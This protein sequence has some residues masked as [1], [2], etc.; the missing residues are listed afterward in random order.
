M[1]K[2]REVTFWSS[3]FTS[4]LI[5]VFLPAIVS[6]RPSEQAPVHFVVIG[7]R[8]G[9]HVPGV[10]EQILEEIKRLRPDFTINV[11]DM[12][13]GYTDDTARLNSQWQQYKSL[14]AS[15]PFPA[16]FVPGNHDILTDATDSVYRRQM[17]QPYYSFDRGNLHFIVLQ[18][19]RW[20]K[21]EDLP[22]AQINWLIN[23][24]KKNSK[25]AYT[26][27]FMH[28]PFWY[29]T[30]ALGKPDTLHTLF[31]TYGVDAVFTGHFHDYFSGKYDGIIYTAIGSSG[32]ET[33]VGPSGLQYHYGWVTVDKGG[34]TISPIRMGSVLPWNEVTSD[35]NRLVFD[36]KNRGL[37]V[38]KIPVGLQMTVAHQLFRVTAANLSKEE[39]I[40]D[41]LKWETPSNW[42]I[43]PA[44]QTI[45]LSPGSVGEF[46]F[47]ASCEGILYPLPTVSLGFP[48][49][50]GTRTPI[51]TSL[52]VNRR[53][54][55]WPAA[56]PPS[57]DGQLSEN[58]WHDPTT[59]FFNS[60][61]SPMKTDPVEFYFAYD[62]SNLYIAARCADRAIDSLKATITARDGA[63]YGEDCIGLFLQPDMGQAVAYQIYFSPLGTIFDQKLTM[64]SE[65]YMDGDRNWDGKYVVKSSRGADYW[66]VEAA[67][68]LD[69]FQVT[70]KS[71][72]AGK[73]GLKWGINF[74]RKQP[75]RNSSADWQVPID[76]DPKS[77]GTMT[78]E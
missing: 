22:P 74:R 56:Q 64:N 5:L 43:E 9:Q 42:R 20:A 33:E 51:A 17:G 50:R 27:V 57:I 47:A 53:V 54:S 15:W 73:P 68:P 8:T 11:G 2:V 41:T 60:D 7:D 67:I 18:N 59:H 55:C 31:R 38:E 76:Y 35:E 77:F 72:V 25:A 4:L 3:V 13:E 48:Y 44:Y 65:G 63:L 24:L 30:T 14:F 69:Q 39:S 1:R 21:S 49:K 12:I 10:Y 46:E 36:M 26:F 70:G 75:R 6:A 32:A 71:V 28:I 78:M 40:E 34:I 58:I 52:L 19:T 37:T 16:Y 23:D 45:T 62:D 61:G 66:T 29:N